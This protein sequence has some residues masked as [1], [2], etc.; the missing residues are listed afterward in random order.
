MK[1]NNFRGNPHCLLLSR[2]EIGCIQVGIGAV[3]QVCDFHLKRLGIKGKVAWRIEDFP[4]CMLIAGFIRGQEA[5]KAELPAKC[6]LVGEGLEGQL[7]SY[8]ADKNVKVLLSPW[9]K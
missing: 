2:N 3:R 5:A 4:A 7:K 1:T 8:L 6:V 9:Q